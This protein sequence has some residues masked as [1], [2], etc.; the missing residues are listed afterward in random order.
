MLFFFFFQDLLNASA[1]RKFTVQ[2]MLL[3]PAFVQRCGSDP[4]L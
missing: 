2:A 4:N 3:E 1:Q